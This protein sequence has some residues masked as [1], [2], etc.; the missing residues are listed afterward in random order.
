M[1]NCCLGW[2]KDFVR[3]TFTIVLEKRFLGKKLKELMRRHGKVISKC[4]G[5]GDKRKSKKLME[6]LS[7]SLS[8][9]DQDI[10]VN[11]GSYIIQS[12]IHL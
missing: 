9:Y 11:H 7:S 4:T 5:K 12:V 2:I 1:K 6:M 3:D 8:K 10:G